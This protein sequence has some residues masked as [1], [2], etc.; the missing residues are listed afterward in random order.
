[1]ARHI[2]QRS[3]APAGVRQMI[4]ERAET[5]RAALATVRLAPEA[6]DALHRLICE[7]TADE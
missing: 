5:A 7:V 3:G 6:T 4:A 2:M 1:V